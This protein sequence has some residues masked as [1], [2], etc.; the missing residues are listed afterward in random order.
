MRAP[1]IRAVEEALGGE[2]EA[3]SSYDNGEPARL[4]EGV[5]DVAHEFGCV[6]PGGRQQRAGVGVR[7]PV[8]RAGRASWSERPGRLPAA[9]RCRTRPRS[10]VRPSQSCAGRWRLEVSYRGLFGDAWLSCALAVPARGVD[11]AALLDGAG[12]WCVAVATA[13]S[14]PGGV[15][16]PPP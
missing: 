3:S 6:W 2:P 8:T 12:R 15:T 1:S 16:A 9:R 7:A 5:T 4:T 14:P 10:G 11:R 13:A